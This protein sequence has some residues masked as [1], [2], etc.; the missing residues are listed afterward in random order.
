MTP[1]LTPSVGLGASHWHMHLGHMSENG[2]VELSRRG[3]LDGHKTSKLHFCEHCVFGKQKQVR[4]S[5]SIHKLKGLLDYLHSDLWGPAKV[6]SMGVTTYML[7]I[8]DDFSCKV[9]VFFLK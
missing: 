1:R 8:I 9:W 7:T 6:S 3:L 4:F 5:S 2:M